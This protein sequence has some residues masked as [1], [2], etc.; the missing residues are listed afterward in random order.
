[1]G[2]LKEGIAA[3]TIPI[4]R[5]EVLG[6]RTPSLRDLRTDERTARP[7]SSRT[8]T[9]LTHDADAPGEARRLLDQVANGLAPE[10]LWDARIL[11]TELVSNSVLHARGRSIE[12][13]LDLTPTHLVIEVTDGGSPAGPAVV[14]EGADALVPHGWG[15]NIVEALTESWGVR[16][17]PGSRTV[18][19]ELRR[20]P[21]SRREAQCA[22]LD[23]A[24]EDRELT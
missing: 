7:V 5:S 2:V 23:S 10:Q 6:A 8:A 4:C 11:V 19:C 3:E 9:T 1:L 15:L 16:D 21:E 13:S 14:R 24:S 20:F 17:G 18:W 12:I 22:G